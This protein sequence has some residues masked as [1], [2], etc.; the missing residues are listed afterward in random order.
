VP[1]FTKGPTDLKISEPLPRRISDYKHDVN[2]RTG[3]SW[4]KIE[5]SVK[6]NLFGFIRNE[7]ISRQAE[8]LHASTVDFREVLMTH[9]LRFLGC[10]DISTIVSVSEIILLAFF[11]PKRTFITVRVS[12]YD[13]KERGHM[14]FRNVD[15]LSTENTALYLR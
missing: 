5:P 14:F 7:N 2:A 8:Q 9:Q 10:S 3:F 11:I 4:L 12:L 6:T 13:T 1:Y 15:W